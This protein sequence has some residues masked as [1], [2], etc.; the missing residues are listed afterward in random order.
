MIDIF[1]HRVF[2]RDENIIDRTQMLCIFWK[3]NASGMR[4]NRDPESKTELT[5]FPKDQTF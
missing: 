1:E 2:S 5:H 3:T 4:N